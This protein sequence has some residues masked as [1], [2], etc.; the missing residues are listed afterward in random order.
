MP[1]CRKAGLMVL[2][3]CLA[4][5]LAAAMETPSSG[6]RAELL[7]RLK[8][9]CGSCHGMTLKGGLGPSLLPQALAGKDSQGLA[10]IV[11]R[12]VPGTPMPPWDI[13]LSAVE[14]AWLVEQ[15]KTGVRP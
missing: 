2:A 3:A 13:E 14:A 9:D 1:D 6:R 12:G 5:V 8:H 7:H 10:D 4:P 15:L 11:L